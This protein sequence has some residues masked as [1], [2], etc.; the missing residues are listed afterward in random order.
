MDTAF[1]TGM[2]AFVSAI[3]VFVG[4]C[5]LLLAII[6][7]AR[8]AYF[9]TASVTLAFV[10][11][12]GVVWS[13]NPLGPVGEMPSWNTVAVAEDA[14]ELDF[15][16]AAQ[17]PE[18]PWRAADEDD[19][20]ETAQVAELESA[21]SGE[22]VFARQIGVLRLSVEA[23]RAHAGKQRD[24]SLTLMRAAVALEE[25]TP[26]PPVTPAPTLP[27]SE[28]LGDLLLEQARPT[29]ALAAYQRSLVL[30]PRRF[31]SLLGLARAARASGSASVARTAYE[32]L[33]IIAKGSTRRAELAEARAFV[34]AQ[35]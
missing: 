15:E 13:I 16:A 35:R 18:D 20:A 23:W 25:S 21:A 4:S 30:Y 5:F 8:L 1:I 2:G 7:G 17:Y 32:E 14:N 22:L 26:K 34:T 11:I 31:N 10:L 28:L 3:I 33:L 27:A 29:E 24:S 19:A 9:V 6:L 12:M